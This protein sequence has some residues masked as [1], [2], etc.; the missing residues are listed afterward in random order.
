[1]KE[2]RLLYVLILILLLSA[3]SV[4][5]GEEQEQTLL[6]ILVPREENTVVISLLGDVSIGD[7]SQFI[8]ETPSYHRTVDEKGYAWPFSTV[9]AFLKEDDL[10]V[11]N[12]EAVLTNRQAHE[13]KMYCLRAEPDHANILLE[14]GV[15]AVNTVN[16]HCGDFFDSGYLDTLSVL[17]KNGIGHFGTFGSLSDLDYVT[18][19]DGIRF[20]F[21]GFSYPAIED[22]IRTISRHIT[23]L[24]EEQGCDVVI[25][26]LHWGRETHTVPEPWQKDYA[27]E[28]INA[29]A[30]VVWGHHPHVLQPVEFYKGKPIL[31]STGNFTFGTISEL[32]PATGIFR[33]SYQ[34]TGDGVFLKVFQVIA[35]E[36]TRSGDYRPRVLLNDSEK[37]AVY[38]KLCMKSVTRG[39]QEM[40]ESF[41]KTGIVYLSDMR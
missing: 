24:K 12:L 33:L 35:C 23:R 31:Y 1:M 17:D 39:C 2:H 3:A 15:D 37:Q 20:G 28:L 36:T 18:E 8:G 25:V 26:S 6:S 19:I 13:E 41:R 14:G 10:T 16:N 40:P 30:D 9:A 21:T 27:K 7:S 5:C 32:D 22:N 34:K 4:C 29:G 11:A 38:A